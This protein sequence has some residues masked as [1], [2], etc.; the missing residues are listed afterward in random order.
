VQFHKKFS[1]PLFALIMALIAL[2]FAFMTGNRGAM[3]GFGVSIGIG[4]AY[5]AVSQVFE[6]IGNLSQLPAAMAAWSPGA[7]FCLIGMYLF[8]KVRT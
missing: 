4:V 1:A 6:Q 3:A 5:W 7:I 2:P 8:T